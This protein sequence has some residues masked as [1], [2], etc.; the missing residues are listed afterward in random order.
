[1]VYPDK[2]IVGKSR[3]RE[4]MKT[5]DWTAAKTKSDFEASSR[6]IDQLWNEKK[7]DQLKNVFADPEKVIFISQ[8]ST[9]R[10]NVLSSQFAEK[11]ASK[12][13]ADFV[14][15][16]YHTRANH[17]EM[18]KDISFTKRAFH[19]REYKLVKTEILK[20]IIGDKE[21]CLVEDVITSGGSVASFT[22]ALNREGIEVKSIAA[23]AGERRLNIDEKTH[24]R[25][26]QALKAKNININTQELTTFL[27]RMEA[28]GL[29]MTANSAKSE[30]AIEKLQADL[31]DRVKHE[32]NM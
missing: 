7:T 4:I 6:I 24:D 18:S 2:N 5:D 21:V 3:S 8:P 26:E 29:I 32:Q 14:L 30:V 16:D 28:G 27:T 10:L 19:P 12:F 20:E 1:M 11:L 22:K 23:L 31:R 15:G 9:S 25:L 13:K 17:S